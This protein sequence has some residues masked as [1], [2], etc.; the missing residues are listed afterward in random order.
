VEEL[1]FSEKYIELSR[2]YLKLLAKLKKKKKRFT[3]PGS[4]QILAE[5]IEAGGEVL[6]SKIH[7]LI[8][9]ICNTEKL[10]G[11]WK[12]SIIVPV[13]RMTDK[14]DCSIYREISVLS[15]SYKIL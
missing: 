1:L 14:T 2:Y 10:P 13:H 8:N 3:S 4:D 11:Q 5:L 6:R 12:E 15:A 7:K 9:S